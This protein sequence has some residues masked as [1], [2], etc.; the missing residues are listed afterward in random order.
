MKSKVPVTPRVLN[1]T[2]AAAYLGVGDDTIRK[3]VKDGKLPRVT[4]LR[5]TYLFDR[6][7]LDA[8]IESEKSRQENAPKPAPVRTDKPRKELKPKPN[9]WRKKYEESA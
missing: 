9:D 7:D 8:L 3:F 1:I 5:H 6:E 2:D 4:I